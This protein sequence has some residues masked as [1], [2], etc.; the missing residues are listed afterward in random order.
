MTSLEGTSSACMQRES[1]QMMQD[2]SCTNALK[3]NTREDTYKPEDPMY[4][5]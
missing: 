4:A 3:G 2:M 5:R 1:P